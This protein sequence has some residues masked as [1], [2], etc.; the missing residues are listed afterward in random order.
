MNKIENALNLLEDSEC[1][2]AP[3]IAFFREV[4]RSQ[5][6]IREHLRKEITFSLSKDEINEKLQK[7]LPLIS[8]SYIPWNQSYLK[9]LFHE[10]CAIMMKQEEADVEDI[11]RL[12]D[13]EKLEM[14]NLRVLIEK[15]LTHD[16][17]SFQTLSQKLKIRENLLVYTVLQTAKPF[18]EVAAE[19]ISENIWKDRWF[20]H[21]CPVCGSCAQIA[22]LEKENGKRILYCILCGSGWRFMRLKCPFCCNENHKKLKFIEEEIGPYRIDICEHCKWYIKTLDERKEVGRET[23]YIPSI[24]DLATMYLDIIAEKNGYVRSCFLPQQ[25]D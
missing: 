22:R 11:Q 18:F 16:N 4:A 8:F 12:V 10:I 7:S 24:E 23:E 25:I 15:I 6:K 19:E 2:S 14:F 21:Y 5:L 20:K 1:I 17:S 13:A 3:T 9:Y